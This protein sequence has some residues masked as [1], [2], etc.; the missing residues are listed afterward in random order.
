MGIRFSVGRP[1]ARTG[2]DEHVRRP[3]AHARA[4]SSATRV[5]KCWKSPAEWICPV[6]P[7]ASRRSHSNQGPASSQ[8]RSLESQSTLFQGSFDD[9]RNGF[10][11][12]AVGLTA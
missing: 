1:V 6:A 3:L 4:M 2:L 11:W 10:N 9:S 12:A 8:I 5:K 7:E